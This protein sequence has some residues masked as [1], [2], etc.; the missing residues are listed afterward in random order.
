M[1][2]EGLNQNNID[3]FT[4]FQ[5]TYD[6]HR[7]AAPP[8]VAELI[9]GYLASRPGLVVDVG[10]GTGLSSFLW[11]ER[12]DRILGI[13]PSDD[14]R[15]IA[16]RRL[17]QQAQQLQHRMSFAAGYSHELPLGPETA[18]VITCSQSFHWMEPV[19]TLAEFA[20][21]LRPGGVFAA[22]DC[23]WPPVVDWPVESA[24]DA[25]LARADR[26]IAEREQPEQLAHKR[27]KASH[28]QTIRDSGHFR[29]VREIVFHHSSP[30]T[31]ERLIGLLLSQGGL[32]TAFKLGS[33][34]LDEPIAAFSALVRAWFADQTRPL[35]LGYRMR[36]GVK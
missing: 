3:R 27:D 26:I 4:G 29:Y 7:P 19:S 11:Q 23:D 31:A 32:Q 25:L 34:E 13:E 15:S 21:V 2:S 24:Y 35:L 8:I 36:L 5:D 17:Q 22:Y 33:D 9:E 30:F 20:R 10:C 28:L 16:E 18:D 12:A 14:M 1:R 6:T